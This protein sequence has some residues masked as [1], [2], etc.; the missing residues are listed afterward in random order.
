MA[1][2]AVDTWNI[3]GDFPLGV[4]VSRK[5][6]RSPVNGGVV[7]RRQTYSSESSFSQA[8]V[9]TFRLSFSMADKSDYN[10]AV[11]LWKKSN[12]GAEGLSYTLRTPYTGATETVIVRMLDAPL[13]ITQNTSASGGSYAFSVQLEEMLHA[14]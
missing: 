12:G 3:S 7:Q 6:L 2:A 11:E 13:M 9:R 5:G 8:G 1:Y 4:A 10:R 14:P